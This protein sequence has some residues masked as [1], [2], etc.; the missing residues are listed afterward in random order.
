MIANT[1]LSELAAAIDLAVYIVGGRKALAA[2]LV[3]TQAAIGNWKARG[4]VPIEHCPEIERMTGGQVTR[5]VLRPNDWRRIW[6]ELAAQEA[7]Q[8][9][10]VAHA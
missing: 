1:H 2:A 7:L 8:A 10:S 5:Q 3:V 6:P 9:Q 4:V